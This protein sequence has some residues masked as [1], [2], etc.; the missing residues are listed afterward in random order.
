MGV[1]GLRDLAAI[2]PTTYN[3]HENT[4]TA[5][6]AHHWIYRYLTVQTRYRNPETYTT[7]TGEELPNITG[8]LQ[9]LPTFLQANITP[10]FVF[11][12]TAHTRKQDE[13]DARKQAREKAKAKLTEAREN[14]N[15]D[16]ARKYKAQAQWLTPKIKETSIELLEALNIPVLHSNASGE[17]Y[18]ATLVKDPSTP[19]TTAYTGD[20]D[21]LLFGCPLTLRPSQ[22]NSSTKVEAMSLQ[23]T[24]T[25][26][27]LSHD[28]LIDAAILIGTDY[29]AGVSGIG[30]KRA[31][32][33]LHDDNIQ[34]I[35]ATHAD[36]LTY[37]DVVTVRKIFSDPPTG[38]ELPP[39]I[40]ELPQPQYPHIEST[41]QDIG[42]DTTAVSDRIETVITSYS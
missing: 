42:I 3:N 15:I 18:A 20:Y 36:E 5:V 30:P 17:G 4:V 14:G 7:D 24:L 39:N 6:D 9:G 11:D 19:I 21:S 26:T 13:I 27:G 16:A 10:V 22:T 31:V 34:N 8:I 33:Y 2:T 23:Q 29:N 35:L 37:D 25:D 38:T 40:T 32:K 1:T 41:L 12:G 28:Q